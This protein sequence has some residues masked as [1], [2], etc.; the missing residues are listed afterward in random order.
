MSSFLK[1]LKAISKGECKYEFQK[2]NSLSNED[3]E[4]NTFLIYLAPWL[5]HDSISTSRVDVNELM[6]IAKIRGGSFFI[7]EFIKG[8]DRSEDLVF[9]RRF[10]IALKDGEIDS[11]IEY[12]LSSLERVFCKDTSISGVDLESLFGP[13]KHE[14]VDTIHKRIDA[15]HPLS[16]LKLH[17]D[18]DD[19]VREIV[20]RK[21][22][23][24]LDRYFTS[25]TEVSSVREDTKRR[26][27]DYFSK[28]SNWL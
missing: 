26:A 28:E 15:S 17:L 10:V 20:K 22:G 19:R 7:S 12:H 6:K 4:S 25:K 14:T 3:I 13:I 24:E 2:R 27:I 8:I 21:I 16:V 18:G 1:N 9:L 11:S 5:A 23:E